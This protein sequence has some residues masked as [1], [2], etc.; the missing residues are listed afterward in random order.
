MNTLKLLCAVVLTAIFSGLAAQTPFRTNTAF[1]TALKNP[2]HVRVD[3]IN[4]SNLDGVTRVCCTLTGNPNTSSRV[5]SCTLILGGQA[6]G[7]LDIDGVDFKRYFQWEEDG[8][9]PVEVDFP[10]H[11][12]FKPE[13]KIVFH[14]VSGDI[15]TRLGDKIKQQK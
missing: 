1:N 12:G 4:N 2:L 11:T 9:I 14:T 13:D 6:Y 15:S 7:S 8:Q 5:D 10:R 3:K